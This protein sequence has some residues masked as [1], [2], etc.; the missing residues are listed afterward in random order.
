ML[1][2]EFHSECQL[3][4]PELEK[5]LGELR[6]NQERKNLVI[7]I[8]KQIKEIV[9]AID[10]YDDPLK[11]NQKLARK[12]EIELE[13][14]KLRVNTL[15]LHVKE[16]GVSEAFME[17]NIVY[18]ELNDICNAVLRFAGVFFVA[19]SKEKYEKFKNGY[20]GARAKLCFILNYP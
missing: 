16:R 18:W 11:I 2:E 15:A 20:L 13:G 9:D 10:R 17:A 4:Q 1:K 19:D 12:F 5:I 7:K 3:C 8:A 6:Q 14:L